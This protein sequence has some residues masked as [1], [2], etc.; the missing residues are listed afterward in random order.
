MANPPKLVSIITIVYNGVNHIEKTIESV[1]GQTY[2]HI[3]YII[4]D[5]GSTD[6]T[7]EVIKKFE[8]RLAYW[9]SEPDKGISDAFNKGIKKAKG[10][11]I[12]IINA[13]DWYEETAV[14]LA[15]KN[16]EGFDIVYGDLQFLKNGKRDFILQGNHK[17][18]TRVMTVNHPT[19]FVRKE[20]YETYGLFDEKYRCAMDYDLMLRF[21]INNCRFKHIPAVLTNMRWNGMSDKNWL[22]GCK[23]TLNIKNKYLP[24]QKVANTLF[25]LKHVLGIAIPK[26]LEKLNLHSVV[27]AYRKRLS[28]QK[29]IYN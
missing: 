18:L 14:E 1:L 4:I 9:V 16:M 2:K 17:D 25:F 8:P 23:E 13:D 7:I 19:A 28:A 26:W 27:K 6:G 29:K 11:I 15:V 10:Q 5:G 21:K 24:D 20:I 22:T 3:E 12:G